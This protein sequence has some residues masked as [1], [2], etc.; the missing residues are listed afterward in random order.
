MA[1]AR[2]LAPG[3]LRA[4]GA[5]KSLP[6]IERF[7]LAGASA[8]AFHLGHRRSEDLDLFSKDDRV[9][10][11]RMKRNVARLEHA[12][13][14]D[15]TD[16]M[17]QVSLS[18]IPVDFVRYQHPPLEP[19]QSGPAGI[20]VASLGDLAAMKLAA[21]ARR[22]I[23]R[24]FWDLYAINRSGVSLQEAGRIYRRRFGRAE[25]DLYHVERALT[26]FV[27]AEIDPVS[28]VGLTPALWRHIKKHFLKE[29]PK[30]LEG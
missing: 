12:T 3:Q 9:S 29:A 21:I 27:D 30:L 20:S 7:Y 19:L 4:L 17:L 24:D 22:G 5:L 11:E 25:T 2:R 26:W 13:I 28:P 18:R 1:K 14:I 8:I 10:L 16:V 6:G 15:E 23:K